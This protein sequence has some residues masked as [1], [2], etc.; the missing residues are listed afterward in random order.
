MGP[1][2]ETTRIVA[3]WLA[4]GGVVAQWKGTGLETAEVE[5]GAAATYAFALGVLETQD[6]ASAAA[7]ILPVEGQHAVVWG[8]ALDK[9]IDEW[10]PS[11][12]TDAAAL[13]PAQYAS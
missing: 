8:Q 6:V 12:Q 7:L 3:P 10:M 2:G 13:D 5:E 9:P 4:P 1:L 11:F